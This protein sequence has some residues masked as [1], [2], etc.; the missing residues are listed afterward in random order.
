MEI[1]HFATLH[2][3]MTHRFLFRGRS[4][5]SQMNASKMLAGFANRHFFH[6]APH[7]PCHPERQ[8]GISFLIT[9][10]VKNKF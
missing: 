9:S 8:L 10:V 5:D 7:M 2:S 3:G 4:G 6:Y 1:P